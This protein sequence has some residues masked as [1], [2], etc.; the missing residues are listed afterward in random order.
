MAEGRLKFRAEAGILNRGALKRTI[1]QVCFDNNCTCKIEEAKGIF[2]SSLFVVI[3][4]DEI[5]LKY[6]AGYMKELNRRY[7]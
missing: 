3:E 5:K 2:S 7:G 6:I 4:G 1:K